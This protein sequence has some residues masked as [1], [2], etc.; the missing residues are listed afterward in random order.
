MTKQR[1]TIQPGEYFYYD[2]ALG[3]IVWRANGDGEPATIIYS[4][5]TPSFNGKSLKTATVGPWHEGNAPDNLKLLTDHQ[6]LI[7]SLEGVCRL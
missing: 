7:W 5:S 1:R 2:G 6:R 3:P 4:A